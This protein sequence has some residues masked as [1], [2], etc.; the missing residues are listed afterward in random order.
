MLE[1][2]K[3]RFDNQQPDGA[4]AAFFRTSDFARV[5]QPQTNGT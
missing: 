5:L 2:T 4:K 1:C 3:S